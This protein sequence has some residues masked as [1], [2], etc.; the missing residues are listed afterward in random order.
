MKGEDAV[1]IIDG[2]KY[3]V[4]GFHKT[5]LNHLYVRLRS[6]EGTKWLNYHIQKNF[7]SDNNKII[8]LIKK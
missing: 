4:E 7:K 3:I 1:I 6:V 2:E 5:E 8:D